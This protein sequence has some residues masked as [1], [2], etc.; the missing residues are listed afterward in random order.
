MSDALRYCFESVR[1]LYKIALL[2]QERIIDTR[3][4][5]IFYFDE[6]SGYLTN[7]L[8][9]LI[10]WCGTGLDLAANYDSYELA[11]A[12]AAL[13]RLLKELNVVHEK[14]GADLNQ[15]G[16]KAIVARFEERTKDFLA[17][18]GRFDVASDNY[19]D[20]YVAVKD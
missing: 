1:L 8:S 15:E 14:H 10:K 19:I 5:Y 2:V 7:K 20:N 3:T 6:I 11:R 17:D 16:H 12:T 9:I 13:I 18:P 4:L